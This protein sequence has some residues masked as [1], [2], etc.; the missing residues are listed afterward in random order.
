M[1]TLKKIIHLDA[2]C[3]YASVEVLNSPHLRGYPIA[4]G[5]TGRRGV[6]ATCNYLARQFGVRSAMPSAQAQKLCPD[7]QILPARFEE[8]RKYSQQIFDIYRQ[9]TDKIET[10]SLDEAYLDVSSS[11]LCSGSATLIAQEIRAKVKHETGLCVSAGV[12]PLKFVAKIAS[13]WNKPNGL[14]VV[15]PDRVESFIQ[16]L[17]VEK[18]PG[19]GPVTAKKLAALGLFTVREIN[20]F[21]QTELIKRFGK[22]GNHLHRMSCGI[23]DREIGEK[24]ERK[25]LS[26][27]STFSEN[28]YQQ[29]DLL[30]RLDELLER[31]QGRYDRVKHTRKVAKRF[32]KLKFSDFSR[33]TVETTLAKN[34]KNQQIFSVSGFQDLL[35]Q[36]YSRA[37]KPVR[38]IGVGLRFETSQEWVQ[39]SLLQENDRS[40]G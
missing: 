10:L 36:A 39:L 24:G 17:S 1:S 30:A 35:S 8:Y 25:S 15:A 16:A 33:T 20:N 26:V 12:A 3:F 7:L 32:I 27:E 14:C 22:F 4:V 13:D 9:Y 21:G 40:V 29:K 19:V 37:Q 34:S 38:L 28:V 6:I 11:S 18:L 2:D 23:D 5:G 31:L